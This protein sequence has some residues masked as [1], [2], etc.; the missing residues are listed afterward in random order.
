MRIFNKT[1]IKLNSRIE[2]S[3]ETGDLNIF[4]PDGVLFA[5][6]KVI[7]IIIP[8]EIIDSPKIKENIMILGIENI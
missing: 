5:G 6:E 3:F 8:E 2:K 4:I 1:K 7:K